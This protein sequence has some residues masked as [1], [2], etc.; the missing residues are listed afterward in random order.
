MQFDSLIKQYD[1]KLNKPN[2]AS[3]TGE[4]GAKLRTLSTS[5]KLY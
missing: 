3:Y 2:T 1:N 4:P 5:A